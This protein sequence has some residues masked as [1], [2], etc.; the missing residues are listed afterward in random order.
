MTEEPDLAVGERVRIHYGVMYRGH[1][2]SNRIGT[3]KSTTSYIEV[4]ISS[5]DMI[6][7]MFR[8]EI[9]LITKGLFEE[10]T[11]EEFTNRIPQKQ[12]KKV[13][14]FSL[15]GE[16][17]NEYKSQTEAVNKTSIVTLLDCL[18]GRQ[19]SAGGYLWSNDTLAP[20]LV[21]KKINQYN[22][23]GN[24]TNSF[25]SFEKLELL[26]FKKK[27]IQRCLYGEIEK[28]KGFKWTRIIL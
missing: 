19:K 15:N 10:F 7:K 17:L 13:Y 8:H 14:Q 23:E 26:G 27:G 2:L 5:I 1:D 16:L 9:Q 6:C 3:I 18:Y 21:I 20:S 4:E 28:Y 24:L 12:P 22:L 25:D 11:D